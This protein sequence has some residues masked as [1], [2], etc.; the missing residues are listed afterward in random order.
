M[1]ASERESACNDSWA[2]TITVVAAVRAAVIIATRES[3][4]IFGLYYGYIYRKSIQPSFN[5]GRFFLSLHE[6]FDT[7]LGLWLCV[8][9]CVGLGITLTFLSFFLLCFLSVLDWIYALNEF[10]LFKWK[11][12]LV[13]FHSGPHLS[14]TLYIIFWAVRNTLTVAMG[15][16]NWELKQQFHI[17]YSIQQMNVWLNF[18]HAKN[19]S[20]RHVH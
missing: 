11:R 2:P 5:F 18:R 20:E 14:Y 19:Y 1:N 15:A 6:H 13:H 17:A 3:T 12:Q 16:W 4:K 10:P 7:M 8:C 9:M